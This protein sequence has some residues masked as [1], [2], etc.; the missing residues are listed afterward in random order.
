MKIALIGYGKMGRLIE[1]IALQ[2]EH[3]IVARIHSSGLEK[4]VTLENIRHADMCID[5]S[6]PD[7]VFENIKVIALSGKSIVMGTTGWYDNMEKIKTIVEDSKI[8]FLYAPNFSIG[9]NVFMKIIS[10]AASILNSFEEFDVGG[11]EYHHNQKI[12]TPSGTAKTIA[13]AILQNFH[14]KN[15][16]VYNAKGKPKPNEL[17]FA[18]LRCGSIPGTHT[19]IFDSPSDTITLTHEARNREGFAI[20][21]IEA[22]EWLKGRTGFYTIQDMIL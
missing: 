5:F 8:G 10:E 18:S 11:I 4:T 20:G 22:A 1:E 21:A 2:K 17:H 15:E 14:R 9:I 7:A 16:I 6:D 13:H 12:D 19:V 3:E